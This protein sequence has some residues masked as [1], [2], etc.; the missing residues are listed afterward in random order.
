ML[1]SKYIFLV[2]T[3]Q[4]P[5]SSKEY[6]FEMWKYRFMQEIEREQEKIHDILMGND[7]RT[8]DPEY[9]QYFKNQ[10]LALTDMMHQIGKLYEA[11]D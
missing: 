6:F 9:C 4:I 3:L 10:Y 2:L 7:A 11:A 8:H 1:T 5:K